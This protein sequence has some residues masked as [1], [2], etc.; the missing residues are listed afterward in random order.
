MSS[1]ILASRFFH[2]HC[3]CQ[4]LETRLS[5]TV[6]V[7][8]GC[9]VSTRRVDD[10]LTSIIYFPQVITPNEK[11]EKFS[12]YDRQSLSELVSASSWPRSRPSRY[13]IVR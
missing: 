5:E 6:V 7:A 12:P 3:R 10:R 4:L 2:G 11:Q 13:D 1:G 8:A 9:M